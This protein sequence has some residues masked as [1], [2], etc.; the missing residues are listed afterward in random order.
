[1]TAATREE[2]QRF[3]DPKVE[4]VPSGSD[5]MQYERPFELYEQVQICDILE[6][7]SIASIWKEELLLACE[8]QP[9]DV[10][11]APHSVSPLKRIRGLFN[12]KKLIGEQGNHLS[13]SV[14]DTKFQQRTT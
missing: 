3:I 1:M 13:R 6:A 14:P 11:W 4:E 7:A 5:L 8:K 10:L 2:A 9:P 12:V